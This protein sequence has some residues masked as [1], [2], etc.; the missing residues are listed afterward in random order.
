MAGLDNAAGRGDVDEGVG[1]LDGGN[2]DLER[3]HI[4][5][6]RSD[7]DVLSGTARA[8]QHQAAGLGQHT[9][10]LDVEPLGAGGDRLVGVAPVVGRAVVHNVAA[11]EKPLHPRVG[12]RRSSVQTASKWS[13]I[14]ATIGGSITRLSGTTIAA[15]SAVDS[16]TDA[17]T[18]LV[19]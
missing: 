11:D 6:P 5:L 12:V 15:S 3:R 1:G 16:A 19:R 10:K 18:A 13:A 14:W 7:L 17:A 4:A 2:E 9:G 8:G